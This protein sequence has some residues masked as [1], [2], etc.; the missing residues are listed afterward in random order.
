MADIPMNRV[1]V[2]LIYQL[3]LLA[4][5]FRLY[6]HFFHLEPS[7]R[8]GL[9]ILALLP[10]L[11]FL[12]K[13]TLDWRF[14]WTLSALF[15]YFLYPVISLSMMHFTESWLLIYVFLLL[16]GTFL[17]TAKTRL[18]TVSLIASTGVWLVPFDFP[19]NQSRYY[20]HLNETIQTRLGEADIVSW[21]GDQ[22]YYYNNALVSSTSDGHIHSEV[23]AHA[24][25]PHFDN[26]NV[27]LIGDDI[28]F[29]RREVV[30]YG[31]QVRHLPYDFSL[32]IKLNPEYHWEHSNLIKHGIT[33]SLMSST[34]TYDLIIIDLQV[35]SVGG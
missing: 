13:R 33:E 19:A 11:L 21:K 30:K 22:W 25:I 9:G 24:T 14:T 15:P 10:L 4:W 26:P 7:D 16:S 35:I 5:C 18:A 32:A 29:T 31:C 34:N 28:G 2:F 8:V 1:V 12:F 17:L 27:L 20:D 3:G 23:L 6:G